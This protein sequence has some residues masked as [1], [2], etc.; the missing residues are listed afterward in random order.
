MAF[1]TY[2]LRCSDGRY[3]V[4]HTENLEVR[5]AQ[6]NRGELP[7]YTKNRRPVELVWSQDFESRLEALTCERQIKGWSRKKKAALIR[8][9]WSEIARLSKGAERGSD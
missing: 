7:G 9:D 8:G 5:V 4:G 6:H 2:M 1:Y 3:Y